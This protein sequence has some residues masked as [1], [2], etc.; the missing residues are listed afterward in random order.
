MVLDIIKL[1]GD[2]DIDLEKEYLEVTKS[3]EM[4]GLSKYEARAYIALVAH[5]FGEAETIAQTARIPRTS[6]YKV[7]ESLIQKGFAF[8]TEGRP[9][10]YKPEHPDKIKE[11]FIDE[12]DQTF[13]KLGIIHE[14]LREKGEPQLVYTI[15]GKQKVIKK[16]EELL[17]KSNESFIISTPLLSE[18]RE[19][20][21]KNIQNALS[22]GVEVTIITAPTQKVP[23]KVRVVRRTS[24]IAT[25]IISDSK[26]A[27]IASPD[28]NAC[29]FTDNT[30]L[31][32]H[33]EGF[34]KILMEHEE[35]NKK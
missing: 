35:L 9:K 26:V 21:L 17:D 25:D 6:A 8:S 30:S 7:L 32:K 19:Q 18:I 2:A 3:L 13:E 14:I 16:I 12:I 29:G 24:L 33:L 28:L 31:S 23:E 34:L 4:L 11:R 27:L 22:R 20:L 15:T 10:I 1:L 5:G